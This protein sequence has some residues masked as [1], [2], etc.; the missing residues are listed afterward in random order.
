M[1]FYEIYFGIYKKYWKKEVPKK[2]LGGPTSPRGAPYPPRAR[3]PGLWGPQRSTAD[4]LLLYEAI[5]PRKN[6]GNT[7]RTFRHR[8]EA[9]PGQ[10]HFCS[11]AERFRRGNFPPGGGNRSLHHHQCSSHRGRLHLHQHLHQH[12]LISKP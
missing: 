10:E 8:L 2:S 5:Y 6:R 9:E 11:P 12:H 3:H 1:K 7:F 4:A